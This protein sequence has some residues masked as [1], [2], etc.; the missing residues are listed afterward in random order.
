MNHV[1]VLLQTRALH[2]VMLITTLYPA[3]EPLM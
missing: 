2:A 3:V 1:D